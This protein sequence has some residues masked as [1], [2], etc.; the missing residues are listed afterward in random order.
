MQASIEEAEWA[1]YLFK[2]GS[3]IGLN[4]NLLKMYNQ[5]LTNKRLQAIKMKPIFDIK[6]N[7][8]PWMENWL[9]NNATENLPQETEISSYVIGGIDKN[10]EEKE[11]DEL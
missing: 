10:I 11:W 1:D 6:D 8:L 7:P 9:N 3:I 5:Y 4:A 2:D